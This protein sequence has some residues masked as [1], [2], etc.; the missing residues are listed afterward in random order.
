MKKHTHIGVYGIVE[1]CGRILLVKKQRGPYTGKWDLPGGGVEMGEDSIETLE[2]EMQEECGYQVKKAELVDV[3]NNRI[4]YCNEQNEMEELTLLSIVYKVTLRDYVLQNSAKI[5]EN[6][7]VSS[8][9]WSGI[10]EMDEH[11][12][13]PLALFACHRQI[14]RKFSCKNDTPV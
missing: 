10:T 12:L 2:R 6:E 8:S 11:C 13:T 14:S 5:L 3:L 9:K 1:N 7:D 4:T